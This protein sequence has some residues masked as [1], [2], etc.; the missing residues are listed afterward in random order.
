RRSN[1]NK[2]KNYNAIILKTLFSWKNR[3]EKKNDRS[4]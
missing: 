1:E 4:R 3:G 2:D